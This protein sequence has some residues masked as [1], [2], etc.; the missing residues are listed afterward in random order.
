[1]TYNDGDILK[2]QYGTL[3]TRR[4]GLWF[5][6]NGTELT[7]LRDDT[8]DYLVNLKVVYPEPSEPKGPQKLSKSP[9]TKPPVYQYNWWVVSQ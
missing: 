8:V 9:P 3:R 6:E 1:M 7:A 2:G 5:S 4:D